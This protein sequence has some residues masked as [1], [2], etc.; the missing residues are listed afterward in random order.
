MQTEYPCGY[1]SDYRCDTKNEA[2]FYDQIDAFM[3]DDSFDAPY[4]ERQRWLWNALL[5]YC[6]PDEMVGEVERC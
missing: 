1:K 6:L 5:T 4:H 2:E 3:A